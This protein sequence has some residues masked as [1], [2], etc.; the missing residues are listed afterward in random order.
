M[1]SSIGQF[2]IGLV[3]GFLGLAIGVSVFFAFARLFGLYTIVRERE[4]QV[5]ML[6]GKVVGIIDE[7]GL[8]ILVTKLGLKAFIVRFFGSVQKV[9]MRLDQEY[10]RS[11]AVNSEEGAPMGIGIWYEMFVSDPVSFLYKNTDPR[12]SLS[13]N[14]SNATV[15]CLSNM[16]LDRKSTRLNSSH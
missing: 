7:P 15:R 5:F 6:F 13:A 12:G 3:A 4:C 1:D 14:V 8:H 16:P 2:F 9:D 11:Q 10:L